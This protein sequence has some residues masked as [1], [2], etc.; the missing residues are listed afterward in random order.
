VADEAITVS[1]EDLTSLQAKLKDL[2]GSL[3]ASQAQAL[4]LILARAGS[5]GPA[6]SGGAPS[7]VATHLRAASAGEPPTVPQVARAIDGVSDVGA[8]DWIYNIWT[9][10]WG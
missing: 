1:E 4:A 5:A 7:A 9:Y 6:S 2:A 8:P 3:P 10:T